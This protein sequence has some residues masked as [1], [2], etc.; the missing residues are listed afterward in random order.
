MSQ[1]IRNNNNLRVVEDGSL[2]IIPNC[3]L[4]TYIV[5][6]NP[7]TGKYYLSKILDFTQAGKSI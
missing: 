4:G 6:K 1:F 7:Q 2:D 5:N 3:P